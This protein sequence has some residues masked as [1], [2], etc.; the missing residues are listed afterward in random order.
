MAHIFRGRTPLKIFNAVVA[1]YAILV[2]YLQ[3]FC[4][5]VAQKGQSNKLVD[6]KVL[7]PPIVL[8]VYFQIPL[9]R[10]LRTHQMTTPKF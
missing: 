5:A 8:K 4:C 10:E 6:I 3:A 9:M 1:S 7:V 2:I